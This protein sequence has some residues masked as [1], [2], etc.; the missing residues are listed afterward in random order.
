M[1]DVK[2]ED[3]GIYFKGEAFESFLRVEEIEEII[4]L[5]KRGGIRRIILKDEKA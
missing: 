2:R 4:I 3:Y 1:T 5:G